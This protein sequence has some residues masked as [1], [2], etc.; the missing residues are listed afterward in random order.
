VHLIGRQGL[1]Q[2][3]DQLAAQLGR[4]MRLRRGARDAVQRGL[5]AFRASA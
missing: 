1:L 5:G 3:G 4:G 2:G